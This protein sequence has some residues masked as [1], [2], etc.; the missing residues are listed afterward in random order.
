MR[1][2]KR[3][4]DKTDLSILTTQKLDLRPKPANPYTG[5]AYPILFTETNQHLENRRFAERPLCS[6]VGIGRSQSPASDARY[7]SDSVVRDR[8]ACSTVTGTQ[9]VL[10]FFG[11][12]YVCRKVFVQNPSARIVACHAMSWLVETYKAVPYSVPPNI[13]ISRMFIYRPIP[14]NGII[15]YMFRFSVTENTLNLFLAL[16]VQLLYRMLAFSVICPLYSAGYNPT[17]LDYRLFRCRCKIWS[18]HNPNR[19]IICQGTAMSYIPL[20][21]RN[22]PLALRPDHVW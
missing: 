12:R 6:F 10:L 8:L 2:G 3:S 5:L 9:L 21:R 18:E 11:S 17:I 7:V 4:T 15:E 14:Q 16:K 20:H 19:Y 1:E 22:A 13:N